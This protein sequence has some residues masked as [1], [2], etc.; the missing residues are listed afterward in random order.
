MK[1]LEESK[2]QGEEAQGAA[3]PPYSPFLFAAHM[4]VA[5][6]FCIFYVDF[7]EKIS[8]H[9]GAI[10]AFLVGIY[11]LV[12][13]GCVGWWVKGRVG[14]YLQN[15]ALGFILFF[16]TSVFAALLVQWA[17]GLNLSNHEIL[18]FAQSSTAVGLF[19]AINTAQILWGFLISLALVRIGAVLILISFPLFSLSLTTGLVIC[20]AAMSTFYLFRS[21]SSS[22]LPLFNPR[23]TFNFIKQTR[24][25]GSLLIAVILILII[26]GPGLFFGLILRLLLVGLEDPVQAPLNG[27]KFWIWW[28]GVGSVIGVC[29]QQ[30][31]EFARLRWRRS[32]AYGTLEAKE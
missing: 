24:P 17:Y 8:V 32:K 1:A 29:L 31:V 11:L 7:I 19:V 25:I 5:Q 22:A 26:T 21:S 28:G 16:P 10:L 20:C 18:F 13:V 4:T 2:T 23:A 3:N 27:F 9:T 12:P 30:M 14:A 6:L 15:G